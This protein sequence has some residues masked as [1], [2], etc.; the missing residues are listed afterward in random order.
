MTERELIQKGSEK[1]ELVM[2]KRTKIH[3]GRKTDKNV[4]KRM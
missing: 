1:T 4:I 2:K 3:R